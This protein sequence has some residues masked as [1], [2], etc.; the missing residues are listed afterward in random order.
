MQILS[1]FLSQAVIT[2]SLRS[3]E[4]DKAGH[5]YHVTQQGYSYGVT[6]SLNGAKHRMH[7]LYSICSRYRVMPLCNVVMPTHTHDIFYSDDF[8]NI[9][10]VMQSVNTSVSKFIHRERIANGRKDTDPVFASYPYYERIKDREHLFYTFK[11][12]YE[13][14]EFL[15]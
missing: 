12:L 13:N 10:K 9:S 11:Y 1:D 15:F 4:V 3:T 14:F 6:F 5:F 7:L 2:E 8:R